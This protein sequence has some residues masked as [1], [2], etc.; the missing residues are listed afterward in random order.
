MRP[1]KPNTIEVNQMRWGIGDPHLGFPC[2][3]TEIPAHDHAIW[4]GRHIDQPGF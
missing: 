2:D 1:K 3:L 4:E